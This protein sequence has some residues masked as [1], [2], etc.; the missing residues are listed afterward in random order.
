MGGIQLN[1]SLHTALSLPSP[2]GRGETAALRRTAMADE[3]QA[4]RLAKACSDFEALFVEQLF[5]T[6]RNSLP[7]EGLLDGGRAEEIY[8][9]MLDQHVAH[10]MAHGHGSL[11]LAHQMHGSLALN[12]GKKGGEGKREG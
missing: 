8:T 6:M 1:D 5:K 10:D 4:Q 2:K 7:A 3:I 9:A 12:E 11:G